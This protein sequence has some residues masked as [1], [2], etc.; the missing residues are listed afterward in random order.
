VKLGVGVAAAMVMSGI[1]SQAVAWWSS[2]IDKAAQLPGGA[3]DALPNHFSPVVFGARGVVPVAVAVFGFVL[4]V[5]A[6]LLLRRT[7]P[8][9]AA[10]LLV[11]VTVQA[12]VPMTVRQHFATPDRI[13]EPLL[14]ASQ[15]GLQLQVQDTKLAVRM[16]VD[17]PGGWVTAIHLADAAGAPFRGTAPQACQ[18]VTSS[19]QSCFAAI[20]ALHLQQ[21]VEYQ[22]G[23]RFG[24]FQ[25]EEAGLYAVLS[26]ALA[27]LCFSR[28]RRMRPA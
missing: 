26:L 9:L 17:V 16:P 10:T 11:L 3:V 18:G 13:T 21:I 20:N 8:A 23:N 27:G 28:I 15:P 12:V 22:P 4:G 2:P 6:G 19:P 14:V 7:L 5:A 1:L 25:G 24:R